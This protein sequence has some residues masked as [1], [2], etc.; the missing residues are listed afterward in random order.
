MKPIYILGAGNFAQEVY[1]EVFLLVNA[2]S[3]GHFEGYIHFSKLDNAI[4]TDVEGKSK[5]F[6]Y[7]KEASFV[8]ATGVKKWRQKFIEI[9]TKKYP[10]DEEHFPNVMSDSTNISPLAV[11][12]LGNV[13]LWNTLVRANAEIGNF[14]LLNAA[15]IVHHDVQLGFNNVLLPQSQILGDSRMGDNNVLASSAVVVTKIIMGNNNTV[16]AG[17]VVFD[18]ISDRKFFQSGIIIDKP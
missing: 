10:L 9:F 3:Y 2:S 7:P 11:Y 5:G 14:N 8:L 1:S 13:F 4:L 16:S 18:N 12:G 15:S 17:E 6:T